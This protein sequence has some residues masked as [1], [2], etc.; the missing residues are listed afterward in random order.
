MSTHTIARY[1]G[2]LQCGH[3]WETATYSIKSEGWT[4]YECEAHTQEWW[5]E[6]LAQQERSL[7][8]QAAYL[9]YMAAERDYKEAYKAF[10]AVGCAW[11]SKEDY[12]VWNAAAYA[13]TAYKVYSN[14]VIG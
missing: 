4:D 2:T 7:E 1:F 6:E 8:F 11:A 13:D 14:T 10:E 12:A 3:C 9:E 5:A